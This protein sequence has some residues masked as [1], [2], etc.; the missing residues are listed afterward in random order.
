M[1]LDNIVH[2]LGGGLP[3]PADGPCPRCA[4]RADVGCKHRQPMG[5]PPLPMVEPPHKS[6]R[7]DNGGGLSFHRRALASNLERG[8]EL[9]GL[10]KRHDDR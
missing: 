6:R 1:P 9:L 7:G 8:A 10:G 3:A 5:V 4:V 2:N